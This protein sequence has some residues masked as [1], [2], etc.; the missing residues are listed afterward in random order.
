MKSFG[1]Y[2]DYYDDFYKEKNYE[3]ECDFIENIFDRF[4]YSKPKSILEFGC[5]T[6]G[7]ALPLA[8]RGYKVK[9][10]DLSKTMLIHARDKIAAAGLDISLSEGDVREI[11]LNQKFDSVLAMFAVI[12]YQTTNSD[13]SQAFTTVSTHLK[14]GGLFVFDNWHG[15]AVLSERP[16]ERNMEFEKEKD[17]IIRLAN[18]V[19]DV[20]KNTVEIHYKVFQL[21]GT[22]VISETKE[23]HRMRYLF[24]QEI[25]YFLVQAG[26][27]VVMFCPFMKIDGKLTEAD[28]N[29]TT[30]ARKVT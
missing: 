27:E 2:A 4:T 23:L 22:K 12:G 3:A 10:I 26:L 24:A 15:P 11:R 8:R 21:R 6:G 18:P 9:G 29:M 28:W 16:A 7:H 20:I 25:E 13:L 17:R 1:S 14:H 30:I 19:L 5:G